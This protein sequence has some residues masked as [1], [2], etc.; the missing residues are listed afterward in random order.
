MSSSKDGSPQGTK[1]FGN[2]RDVRVAGQWLMIA[3]SFPIAMSEN[4]QAFSTVSD[5]ACFSR[6]VLAPT[7]PRCTSQSFSTAMP[8]MLTTSQTA[9]MQCA[10]K[11][12]PVGLDRHPTVSETSPART[13]PRLLRVRIENSNRA[14]HGMDVLVSVEQEINV[15]RRVLKHFEVLCC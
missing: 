2:T 12:G 8:R 14:D 7:I 4:G 15:F 1:S 11:P 6:T 9:F 10:L 13:R 5:P 3:Y